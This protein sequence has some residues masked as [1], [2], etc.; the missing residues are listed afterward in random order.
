MNTLMK[1]DKYVHIIYYVIAFFIYL[2]IILATFAPN[3]QIGII[4]TGCVLAIIPAII[5]TFI[6]IKKKS[7]IKL[8]INIAIPIG[9]ILI[10]LFGPGV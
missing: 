6:G 9:I 10:Y 3:S 2:D 1:T 4:G 5:S 7:F 8:M